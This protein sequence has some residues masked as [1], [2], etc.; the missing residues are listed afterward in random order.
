MTINYIPNGD[1]DFLTWAQNFS[2]YL[3]HHTEQLPITEADAL[4]VRNSVTS[5][6]GNLVSHSTAS[7]AA[8]AACAVKD[9]TRSSAED[10]IRGLVRQFQASPDVT[11]DQRKAMGIP[12]HSTGRTLLT[13]APPTR[14]VASIDT[15]ERLCHT[16]SYHDEST[17]TKR[18]R[19]DHAMGCEIWHILTAP[20]EPAPLDKTG[21]SSLGINTASPFMVEYTGADAGKMAHYL[22]RWVST[23]GETGRWSQVVSAVIVG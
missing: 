16:I 15:S 6:G 14:P 22:L 11:D 21:Y 9:D 19:P 18:A 1:G 2:D 17:P 13:A 20:T 4:A 8:H 3:S 12:V 23:T 7:D 5:F 10:V